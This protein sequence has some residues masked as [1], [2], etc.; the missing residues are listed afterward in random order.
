M[1]AKVKH[2]IKLTITLDDGASSGWLLTLHA[3]ADCVQR[4]P[5]SL[6]RL[7]LEGAMLSGEAVTSLILSEAKR[8]GIAINEV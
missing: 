7:T 8:K 6:G 2:E 4:Q 5:I 3:E 1:S